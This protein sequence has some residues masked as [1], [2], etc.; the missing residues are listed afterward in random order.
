MLAVILACTLTKILVSPILSDSHGDRSRR[1]RR[2]EAR[3]RRRRLFIASGRTTR[4]ANTS[5]GRSER[6]KGTGIRSVA[7]LKSVR[8][9]VSGVAEL[10]G[11]QSDPQRKR[12][13]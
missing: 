9:P 2:S 6:S 13:A 8:F 1:S 7:E 11:L 5:L 10:R 4:A 12:S 3:S